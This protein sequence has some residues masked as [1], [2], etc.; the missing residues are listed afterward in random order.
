MWREIAPDNWRVLDL[1][2][3][4]DG[5]MSYR[6][7]IFCK[8]GGIQCDPNIGCMWEKELEN[9]NRSRDCQ[10]CGG[11]EEWDVGSVRFGIDMTNLV[12]VK[13]NE[14]VV[15]L[16]NLLYAVGHGYASH[17]CLHDESSWFIVGWWRMILQFPDLL[18]YDFEH[19]ALSLGSEV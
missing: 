1:Y 7:G 12:D 10:Y 13:K 17:D 4:G 9:D 11:K 8:C 3:K 2:S 19:W 5:R 15:R 14:E 18:F 6:K 16:Q